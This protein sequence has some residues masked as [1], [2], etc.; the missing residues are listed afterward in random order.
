MLLPDVDVQKA[1]FWRSPDGARSSRGRFVVRY[2]VECYQ[3]DEGE[4]CVDGERIPLE[5]DAL[6]FCRPGQ[7]RFSRFPFETLFLYFD[8]A[9]ST[10][11][12]DELLLRIPTLTPP[13]RELTEMMRRL[14]ALSRQTDY[15][16]RTETNALLLTLLCRL[17]AR[18]SGEKTRFPMRHQKEIYQAI[19]FMKRHIAV[20]LTADEIAAASGYSTA[21]FTV[22]FRRMLGTTPYDYFLRLKCQQ[23]ERR[24]LSGESAAEVAQVLG[25]SSASYFSYAFKRICGHSPSS[26]RRREDA[27]NYGAL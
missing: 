2:E 11:A 3:L 25:F 14:I 12:F 24:L 4:T 21:H 15:A 23:A 16:S 1:D 17:A 10:A 19:C 18:P 9:E 13:R 20:M 6:L 26:L 8:A 27:E 7:V 5:R 22:L